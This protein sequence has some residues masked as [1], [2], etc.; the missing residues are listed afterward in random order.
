MR[1]EINENLEKEREDGENKMRKPLRIGSQPGGKFG[2]SFFVG[3]ITCI[4]IYDK[5]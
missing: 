4:T 5:A 3:R 1:T 2:K